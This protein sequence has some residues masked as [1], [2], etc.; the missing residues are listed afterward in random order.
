MDTKEPLKLSI[1]VP[2]IG[3]KKEV[4]ELLQSIVDCFLIL[5]MRLLLSIK[6]VQIF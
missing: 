3:R 4:G 5:V 6:M 1:L 2:T